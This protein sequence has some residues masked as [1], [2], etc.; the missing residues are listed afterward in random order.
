MHPTKVA[1]NIIMCS[2]S[3]L[4]ARKVPFNLSFHAVL[5]YKRMDLAK[6]ERHKERE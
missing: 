6:N 3:V 2:E 1:L 4:V 5:E